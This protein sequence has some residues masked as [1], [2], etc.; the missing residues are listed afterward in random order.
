MS[1]VAEPTHRQ[2]DAQV[3]LRRL[4]EQMGND[5]ATLHL[6]VAVA[7]AEAV[8]ARAQLA[9][10]QTANRTQAATMRG[11]EE[12]ITRLDAKVTQMA[13]QIAAGTKPERRARGAGQEK[14]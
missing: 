11:L 12:E 3:L 2:I 4:S 8:Q 5:L 1:T 7:E 14:S 6:R 9:D 10:A 13:E